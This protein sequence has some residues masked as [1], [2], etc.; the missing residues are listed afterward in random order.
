MHSYEHGLEVRR[1]SASLR[2]LRCLSL[3]PV[4]NTNCVSLSVK[5]VS[6]VI[7]SMVVMNIDMIHVKRSAGFLAS[8]RGLNGG[9]L[10]FYL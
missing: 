8:H 1:G 5:G 3:G 4:E 7:I 2:I 10:H 9:W 6:I